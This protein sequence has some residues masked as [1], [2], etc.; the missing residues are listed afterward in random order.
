MNASLA[1]IAFVAV[2]RFAEL[3]HA[4]RNTRHLLAKG[5]IE[6]GAT[7]YPL[8]I[9]LHA[10][11]LIALVIFLPRNSPPVWWLVAVFFILQG[12]RVWA[13][14][15]LGSRWTTRIIT[16]PDAPRVRRGPYRFIAHPNYVVV[17]GEIAILPLAL[18]EPWVALVF[19]LLNAALLSVR[20]RA[21]EAAL[22]KQR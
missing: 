10:G 11:W 14:A 4:A 6:S 18:G 13:M 16:L 1:I 9:A 5:G 19:S 17:V 12:V 7:H 21:E 8:F 3:L 20:I 2:Q 15:S 22:A